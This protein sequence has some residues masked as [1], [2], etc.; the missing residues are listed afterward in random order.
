MQTV[1][2]AICGFEDL[3]IINHL[4]EVHGVDPNTYQEEGHDIV[5]Q[6]VRDAF[7]KNKKKRVAAAP[8]PQIQFGDYKLQVNL[9]VPASA[10][11][12]VPNNYRVPRSGQ[13][14]RDVQEAMIALHRRRNV[15]IHGV[16]GCG[17]DALIHALAGMTR[18]PSLL[19]QVL[20]DCD[21]EAWLYTQG[22]DPNEGDV[23]REGPLL[24]AL[25]DGYQDQNGFSHPM[26][27]LIT[28]FDRANPAQ[29]E[30]LRLIMDSIEGRVPGPQGVTYPLLPG[31][32]IVCTGNSCGAGDESGMCVSSQP[33]DESIKDRFGGI[34]K[35]HPMSWKDEGP[36]CKAKFP[37]LWE[38]AP[39]AFDGVGRAVEA[40]RA[41]I[42]KGSGI[43]FQLSHR[44][45]CRW[46]DQAEGIIAV[47][48]KVPDNLLQRAAKAFLDGAQD[49][50]TRQQIVKL[51][52][53]HIKGGAINL[54]SSLM[55]DGELADVL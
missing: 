34:F 53:P 45:V 4:V 31:T 22:F 47:T 38:K 26:L 50:D 2:C 7:P 17:K 8:I 18:R 48:G 5:S 15:Y 20:P 24:K 6:E 32:Q 27:I 49:E 23:W 25:R 12:P 41:E 1:K 36:I 52:D 55:D 33:M 3:E 28:D 43:Y 9:A 19:F 46:L 42:A 14:S 21:V 16:P 44:G 37:L 51:I 30:I 35:F 11:L 40:I 10:C 54:G 13:L 29:A 39:G